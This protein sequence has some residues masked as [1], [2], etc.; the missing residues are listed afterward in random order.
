MLPAGSCRQRQRARRCVEPPR[1][2][3]SARAAG[4]AGSARHRR[5]T[6][7]SDRPRNWRRSPR[8]S[9]RDWHRRS[10][11]E[12]ST[13]STRT[14]PKRSITCSQSATSCGHPDGVRE[15]AAATTRRS[16]ARFSRTP[17]SRARSTCFRP[18]RWPRISWPSSTALCETIASAGGGEV[19][20]F[21]YD[22][23]TPQDARRADPRARARRARAIP[24]W[25]T[26]ESCRTI[27]GGRSCSRTCSLRRHRRAARL[28]RRVRQ[29]SV[30]R[31]AS[32]AAASAG[33][34]DRIRCSS[35]RRR[36]LRIRASWPSG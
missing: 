1:A 23:D 4:H 14:R 21:T 30:Q 22:G 33:T 28:S 13:S 31:A 19:G 9:T 24:T 29:P 17:S 11:R 16:S 20:V 32:P 8:R 18:K 12:A 6:A 5:P 7:S 3:R 25:C 36:R 2:R 35:V 26:P 10:A 15:D 27:R 34:T